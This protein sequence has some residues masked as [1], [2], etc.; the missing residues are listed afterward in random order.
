MRDRG[1][2]PEV[3]PMDQQ[4]IHKPSDFTRAP[5]DGVAMPPLRGIK[6][7]VD[8]AWT[9][10]VAIVEFVTGAARVV[11]DIDQQTIWPAPKYLNVYFLM[12]RI[13][14][15][16]EPGYDPWNIGCR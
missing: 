14:V 15:K 5:L 2:G 6:T 4:V 11:E 1:G 9:T 8:K 13:A 10:S 3:T 7:E 16:E 12:R